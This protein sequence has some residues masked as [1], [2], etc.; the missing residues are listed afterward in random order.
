MP[1]NPKIPQINPGR[2]ECVGIASR[3]KEL[4]KLQRDYRDEL[5]HTR[6]PEEREHILDILEGLEE[7][8]DA[9]RQELAD[10]MCYESPTPLGMFLK[11]ISVET[12]Q[13]IQYLAIEGTGAGND[14]SISL[15]ANK[16]LLVRVYLRSEFTDPVYV[17]GRLAVYESDSPTSNIRRVIEPNQLVTM[18][19]SS[20]SR[21]NNLGET[22]NFIIPAADCLGRIRFEILAWV[23]G[24]K[25]DPIYEAKPDF[26]TIEFFQR[27]VPIVHLYPI[28]FTQTITPTTP[29]GATQM[30]LNA[31]TVADCRRTMELAVRM[32]PLVDLD[33][34][35]ARTLNLP[36]GGGSAELN[37]LDDYNKI[38]QEI[39]KIRDE[40]SPTPQN[41]EIFVGMIS[42][43]TWGC[44]DAGA[45]E[46]IAGDGALFAHELGHLLMP[47]KDH[48]DDAACPGVRPDSKTLDANYPNYL[49][50]VQASGIG[51]FGVDLGTSPPTLF[52]PDTQDI[53]SY[54][55]LRWISPYNYIR[56][57]T[58]PMPILE[59]SSDVKDAGIQKLL[60]EFRVYRDGRVEFK[61]GMHLPGEP[62]SY[63]GKTTT[64]IFVEMYC[65]DNKLLASHECCH[66]PSDRLK[67]APYEDFREVL[68]W[69]EEAAYI[70]IIRDGKEVARW[71]IEEPPAKPPIVDLTYR[72]R[73]SESGGLC[74]TVTWKKQDREQ[75]LN[76]SLRFTPDDGHSWVPVATVLQETEVDV[77]AD[78]LPGGEKCR[79]Q[80]AVSTGFRTVQVESEEFSIP[81]RPSQVFILYPE[82]QTEVTYGNPIWLVGAAIPLLNEKGR[83]I[84]AFWSSNRDG[85]L[86]DGFRVLVTRLSPGRHVITLTAEARHCNEVKECVTVWVKREG[87]ENSVRRED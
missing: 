83:Q 22:L 77:D 16:P 53:M 85:F 79:F 50:T 13:S 44:A 6:D 26:S 5:K 4:L 42:G 39:Q 76:Y 30:I 75:Q 56:A 31:P 21:R 82:A 54:C 36:N 59:S 11:I 40:T 78:S 32:L 3:I 15:V 8:I 7:H 69:Y 55:P 45:I 37:T 74:F 63:P 2:P 62:R 25:G 51:E 9:L 46:S 67:T 14:N 65:A 24:H 71:E 68:P 58:W 47:G 64:S 87:V 60:L 73:T 43:G 35:Y 61:S 70:L 27:T 49:N 17:D 48:V 28:N 80:L 84:D 81:R 18:S 34:R 72:E 41:H 38:R 19:A 29:G 23:W 20:T 86:G 66:R 33:I 12:T 52:G 10:Q 57:M 1:T